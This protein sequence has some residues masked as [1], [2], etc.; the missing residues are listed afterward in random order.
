[1]LVMFALVCESEFGNFAKSWP[2]ELVGPVP[3]TV[4]DSKQD[5]TC[6]VM[7]CLSKF[8]NFAESW[9]IEMAG[10]VLE[11]VQDK[12]QDTICFAKFDPVCVSKF[13]NCAASWCHDVTYVMYC[14]SNMKKNNK[15]NSITCDMCPK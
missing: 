12:K 14:C 3:E 7:L 2:I 8:G 11:T 10:P 15:C 1:M 5:A 4:Q 6:F 9:L 13:G